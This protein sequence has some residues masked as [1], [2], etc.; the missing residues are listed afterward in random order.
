MNDKRLGQHFWLREFL[1]SETAQRANR[2]IES[3][4]LGIVQQLERLVAE[5]LD[6]LREELDAPITVISG[7]RPAWLNTLV[8]GSKN[9]DHIK[10]R[11]ADIVPATMRNLDLCKLA[12][13]MNLPFKQCILEFPPNGWVH[14]SI[15]VYNVQPRQEI[16]TATR[17]KAGT[18]YQKGLIG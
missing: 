12:I 3:P 16:L 5:I 11:A 2:R 4:P 8:K 10:G 9:S 13:V 6:P 15:D 18:V 1:R 14:L 17:G 7:W